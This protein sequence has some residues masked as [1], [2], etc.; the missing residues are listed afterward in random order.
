M[1][2]LRLVTNKSNYVLL[3]MNKNVITWVFKPSRLQRLTNPGS[4]VAGIFIIFIST[5]V[6][7]LGITNSIDTIGALLFSI[8]ACILGFSLVVS[9]F[10]YWLSLTNFPPCG[11]KEGDEIKITI[12]ENTIRYGV[13]T[14]ADFA[15]PKGRIW[16]IRK[17]YFGCFTLLTVEPFYLIIPRNVFDDIR[18]QSWLKDKS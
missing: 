16:K 1:Q 9:N 15:L 13:N 14:L 10:R 17:G 18:F 3:T 11:Y 8:M 2:L 6:F 5:I 12:D 4:A 7:L